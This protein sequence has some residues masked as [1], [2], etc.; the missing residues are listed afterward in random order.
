MRAVSGC[1]NRSS[2]LF[3]E[4]RFIVCPHARASG[5]KR[6]VAGVAVSLYGLRSARNWGC[7]DFTDL[8]ALIDAFAPAGAAFHRAESAARDRQSRSRTT[9]ARICRSARCIA[10][11]FIWMWSASAGSRP[12]RCDARGRSKR[13][14]PASSSNTSASRGLK[15]ACAAAHLSSNFREPAARRLRTTSIESEQAQPL[16][17]LRRLTARST[18][19]CIGAIRTSGCGPIGRRSIAI[20]RSPAVARIR[21]QNIATRCPVFQVSAVADRSASSPR[22]RPT[23]SS[24][25]MQI[26]LYHDLALA[27]D[28]YGADLWAYRPFYAA[29]LPRRRASR[30]FLAAAARTGAFRRPIA[31]RIAPTAIELFA[32]SSARRRPRRRAA[33]RSRDALLPAVLDSR[34]LARQPTAPTCSDYAG[35]SAGHSGA[36]KRARRISS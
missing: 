27:T 18:K 36:R 33:H 5:R 2:R 3:A 8:R 26:G 6:R 35:G 10:T 14:A 30:R 21:R 34:R 22:R 7:G 23:R 28:R 16:R 15:L 13:C 17:R 9:P 1:R 31:R 24:A 4:A 12:G 11:S 19:R 29:G 20:P 32:Q 25:G